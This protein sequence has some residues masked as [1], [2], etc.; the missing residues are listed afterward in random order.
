LQRLF[1]KSI[2]FFVSRDLRHPI[3]FVGLRHSAMPT[4]SVPEATVHENNKP[5]SF[6][7]KVRVAKDRWMPPPTFD[8]V[9]AK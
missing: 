1:G 4:A 9:T 6:E 2:A 8:S 7:D 3:G 5:P